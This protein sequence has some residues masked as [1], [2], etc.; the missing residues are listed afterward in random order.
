[1]NIRKISAALLGALLICPVIPHNRADDL[2]SAAEEWSEINTMGI[3]YRIYGDHAEVTDGKN[4]H[5]DVIIPL[6]FDGKY[7][8]T[9]AADAFKNADITSV[10]LSKIV[11]ISKGSFYG[12][13]K[14]TNVE[15]S[16]NLTT[17]GADAFSHCDSLT[18]VILP[19]SLESLGE[20]A[21][22]YDSSLASVTFRNSRCAIDDRSLTISNSASTDGKG[23]FKG[24]IIGFSDSTADRYAKKHGYN[25][26]S[27]GD[28]PLTATTTTTTTT[29]SRTTTTTTS[30]TTSTTSTTT[31]TS[32]S[33]TTSNTTTTSTTTTSAETTTTVTTAVVQGLPVLHLSSA[34][35]YKKDVQKGNS[36]RVA[37]SVEGADKLYSSTQIYVYFDGKMRMVGDAVKGQAIKDLNDIQH[38][39]DTGDFIFLSTAGSKNAGLDG[40]MWYIDF[41][42]PADSK[43]GDQFKV[44]V[45]G[46]K[47]GKVEPLFTNFD[48]DESG[49][50]MTEH[51]FSIPSSA[52]VTVVED[53]PFT[54]GDVNDDG[55]I[56]GVDASTLLSLYS[57]MSVDKSITL[58]NYEMGSCD[59]NTDG[60]VDGN[61]AS[62]ILS[63]YAYAS[64]HGGISFGDYLKNI[65]PAKN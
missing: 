48:D 34:N 65:K 41:T 49:L 3:T 15:F 14:L 21:F 23:I 42:L 60:I 7:I 51:A 59:V 63:Y 50:A 25:F 1:M 35:I 8:T 12:C 45:G 11:D 44:Y 26:T 37:L 33:T 27:L 64:A 19:V 18:S 54:V 4:A 28:D 31:T 5:G 32:T 2:I 36:C 62:T 24:N 13:D 47:Y 10:K 30:T 29:T 39:G 55:R 43:V 61:D 57:R 52:T 6:K 46:S 53:P 20:N 56:D 38:K 40:D 9:I 22:A 16:E 58:S 17:I